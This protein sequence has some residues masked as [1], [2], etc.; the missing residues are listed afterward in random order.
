MLLLTVCIIVMKVSGTTPVTH[1]RN[2]TPVANLTLP[3]FSINVIKIL[4]IETGFHFCRYSKYETQQTRT[5]PKNFFALIQRLHSAC[6]LV[7]EYLI[8]TVLVVERRQISRIKV[9][10]C[11]QCLAFF[12][13]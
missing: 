13:S 1:N 12:V 5:T 6:K 8:Y 3:K 4:K 9:Q 10:Y 11:E 2:T 7:K